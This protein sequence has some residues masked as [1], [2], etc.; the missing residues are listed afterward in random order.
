[1]FTSQRDPNGLI[2][3]G[4]EEPSPDPADGA[5][6]V[7][8]TSD[9]RFKRLDVTKSRQALGYAPQDDRFQLIAL[10]ESDEW[11]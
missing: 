4:I 2:L 1:M 3:R 7:H 8:A 9:N 5:V 6:V 11:G 10:D